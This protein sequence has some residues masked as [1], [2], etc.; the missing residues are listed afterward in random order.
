MEELAPGARYQPAETLQGLALGLRGSGSDTL[1]SNYTGKL[2]R[3][4]SDAE[5]AD[6]R[7]WTS[8]CKAALHN[9]LPIP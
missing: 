2:Q 8:T 4:S 5:G 6:R 7:P 9:M 1:K 3:G